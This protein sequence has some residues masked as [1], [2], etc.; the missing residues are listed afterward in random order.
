MLLRLLLLTL[1]SI[2]SYAS[3]HKPTLYRL[4]GQEQ[5]PTLLVFGGIHGN[6]PGG[7][8]APAILATHYTI[9]KGN[10]WVIPNLNFDSIIRFRRGIHGDMNRKFATIDPKDPDKAT[11]EMAKKLIL[12]KQVDLILNLHDGHGFYRKEWQNA[13]FNPKAWGQACI[14]DQ[15]CIDAKKFGD[16]D[17][18]AAAVARKLNNH[19]I[20][21]H[22]I[23]HV[24]N[25]ETKIKDEQMRLSLTYYAITHGKPALAIETS[26]Q[27][28]DLT[29]KVFY[30]LRAIEAFMEVMGIR[31]HRDFDMNP[32][33]IAKIIHHYG[34]I[35]IN[36]NFLIP[37]DNVDRLLRFVPLKRHGN[38]ITQALSPLTAL[39]KT[40]R[41]YDVMVG[42]LTVTTLRPDYFDM[43]PP[44]PSLKVIADG[45]EKSITVPGIFSFKKSFRIQAPKSYRINVIGYARPGLRNENN[46]TIPVSRLHPNRAM[47]RKNRL[48]RVEIYRNNRFCGMIIARH[49]P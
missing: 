15:N 23:F 39:K 5:G 17:R 1:L 16:L 3:M 29:Q 26:K 28:T 9:E 48:F 37:L 32:K 41:G 19:V 35:V 45:E 38:R 18:L 49:E 40:K 12:D 43:A 42:H 11:V 47:D 8:F 30:Q 33:A 7:Y 4:Q 6:E 10:L 31:F 46:L 14:I 2:W 25:T 34:D 22:H 13:I 44:P 20:Q 21:N 27:I 24:K 36:G